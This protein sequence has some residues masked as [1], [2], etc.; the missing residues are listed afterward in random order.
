MK[1]CR[2]DAP[3][4]DGRR[5]ADTILAPR[6]L[7]TRPDGY[8]RIIRVDEIEVGVLRHAVEQTQ[9]P[10]VRDPVPPHVRHLASCRKATDD[11][12]NQIEP[13]ALA[14]LL[15]AREEQ[16]IAE[17]DAEEGPR[18]IDGAPHG[19]QQAEPREVLHRIVEGAVT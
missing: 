6:G 13:V 18:A 7:Q 8:N 2:M 16:L 17:A 15:A 5:K 1:L 9:A 10:A 19:R 11:P 4:L 12:G 14:E 3:K